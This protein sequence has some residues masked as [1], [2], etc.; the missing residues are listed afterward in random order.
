MNRKVLLLGQK[1]QPSRAAGT[2]TIPTGG[3]APSTHER[4]RT[5]NANEVEKKF[6]FLVFP[7][8]EEL[9]L[10]GP[11][12][13]FSLWGKS[14]QGPGTRLMVAQTRDPVVCAKGMSINPQITFNECPQLDYLLVP[15]GE[16][17]REQVNNETL[18]RFV[19]GRRA[20]RRAT[21]HWSALSRLTELGDVKVC[22]ERVVRDGQ[23]WTAAG[24]SAGIDL[25]LAFIES[26]AGEAVAGK[27][28]FGAEYYPSGRFFGTLHQSPQAPAYLK[29]KP[30]K[31]T[32]ESHP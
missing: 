4:N 13:M 14:L 29:S 28:Q 5:M 8:L 27:V 32:T 6:G 1:A 11:W 19:A 21:T 31:Q 3:P 16:G 12:E 10:V 23:V 22:Q 26:V 18:I 24:I 20:G 2:E 17:T 15:G 7:G 9:D 30:D 25:A